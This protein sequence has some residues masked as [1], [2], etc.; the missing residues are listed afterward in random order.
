M[1]TKFDKVKGQLWAEDG[2]PTHIV[3][4]PSGILKPGLEVYA[5]W[6]NTLR[7]IIAR[8][9]GYMHRFWPVCTEVGGNSINL[10]LRLRTTPI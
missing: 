6:C 10:T 8:A 4:M 2:R 9:G 1:I 7:Y 5:H 3:V